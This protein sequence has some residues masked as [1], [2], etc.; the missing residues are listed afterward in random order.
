[1]ATRIHDSVNECS[2]FGHALA[3]AAKRAQ[4]AF[5]VLQKFQLAANAK[6]VSLHVEAPA[7]VPPVEADLG[8]IE[9]VLD[10]LIGNALQHTPSGSV[11]AD[12]VSEP[13]SLARQA[14]GNSATRTC[15]I[16]GLGGQTTG[17]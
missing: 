9:R 14:A 15:S 10:N 6:R 3:A 13:N 7:A 4:L 1:M 17:V 12:S 8:L 2:R 16:T 11:T 5:D